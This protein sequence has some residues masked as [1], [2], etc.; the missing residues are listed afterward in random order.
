MNARH[1]RSR[2]ELAG[3]LLMAVTVVAAIAVMFVIVCT[4]LRPQYGVRP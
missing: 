3:W 1:R 2:V 4:V